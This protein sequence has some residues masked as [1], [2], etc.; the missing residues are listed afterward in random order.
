MMLRKIKA[1]ILLGEARRL[2]SIGQSG[3]AL[4]KIIAAY[5]LLGEEPPSAKLPFEMNLSLA[6]IAANANRYRLVSEALSIATRQLPTDRSLNASDRS[7]AAAYIRA[8][9]LLCEG[10]PWRDAQA[11][12]DVRSGAKTAGVKKHLRANFPLI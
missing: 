4:Q 12:L 6:A 9:R 5:A 1:A 3:Q 8:L 7:Y 10:I 11:D 2:S